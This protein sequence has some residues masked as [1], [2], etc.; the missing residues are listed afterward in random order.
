LIKKYNS[1]KLKK[2]TLFLDCNKPQVKISVYNPYANKYIWNTNDTISDI[3]IDKA[4]T[5]SVSIHHKCGL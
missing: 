1:P 5:Y 4:G 3:Y 2:E